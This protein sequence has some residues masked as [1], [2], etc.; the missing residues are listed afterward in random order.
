VYEAATGIPTSIFD[1]RERADRAWTTLQEI[2]IREGQDG[3]MNALPNLW[4]GEQ[5]FKEYLTGKPITR[6]EVEVMKNEYAEE[7]K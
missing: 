4:F 5:G 1:L 2:N 7:W 3:S 6:N